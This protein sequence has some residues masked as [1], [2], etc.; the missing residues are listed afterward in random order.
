MI[1]TNINLH[2]IAKKATYFGVI[3]F[4]ETYLPDFENIL[5]EK[6][7]SEPF[8]NEK[9]E[10]YLDNLARYAENE[11]GEQSYPF[12]FKS[13]PLSKK[14]RNRKT[15]IGVSISAKGYFDHKPFFTIEAKR[16]PTPGSNREKEYVFGEGGGI[17]RFK[18]NEHGVDLP[19]NAMIAYIE[20]ES[21]EHWHESVNN[22]ITELIGNIDEDCAWST[23]ELLEKQYF[24]RIAFLKS[25][26]LRIN[27][28][29]TKEVGLFHFWVKISRS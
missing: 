21:F 4:L 24:D 17:V 25:N 23:A 28:D 29:I 9:L 18:R 5:F 10:H 20:K 22:W 19:H 13:E 27:S 7:D 1:S 6:D 2:N 15:D 16:L 11:E 8:L 14:S 12:R 26:H 3:N